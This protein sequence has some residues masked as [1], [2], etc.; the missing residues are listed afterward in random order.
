MEQLELVLK[1][2]LETL[3][4][5]MIEWNNSELMAKVEAIL[6]TYQNQVY[7]DENIA[8][9]KED[10]AK[11]NA[12]ANALDSERLEIKKRYTAP[13]DKFTSEVNNVISVV[14]ATANK[15][16]AT[17]TE[18]DEKRRLEKKALVVDYFTDKIGD[19]A[20]LVSY[21]K[22]EDSKWYNATV[23]LKKIYAEID[24]KFAKIRD[25]LSVIESLNSVDKDGLKAFYF[26]SLNIA[27][28][29]KENERLLKER[30]LIE[31]RKAKE[32]EVADKPTTIQQVSKNTNTG[33]TIRFEVTG[34]AIEIQNLKKFLNDNNIKYKAI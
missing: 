10:R 6:P 28:A 26:R 27:L 2:D 34:T 17:I 14:K 30:A 11:L 8:Q 1:D 3:I 31:E 22:L 19:L 20:G 16:G 21:E 12:F 18:Y 5:A 29:I 15:I 13:L 9:A 24:E 25:D 33:F 32:S 23:S 7:T 4:P